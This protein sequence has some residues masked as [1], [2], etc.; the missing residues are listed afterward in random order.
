MKKF[1]VS[2]LALL[3]L[4]ACT[5]I[6]AGQKGVVKHYGRVTSVEDEGLV[7]YNPWSTDVIPV[8]VQQMKWESDT[9]AYT[10]DVQQA[11]IKF[12][13]TYRLDPSKVSLVYRT[14]GEDWPSVLI[15][16]V[17]EQSI[18]E[19]MGRSD[20]VGDAINNRG[21]VQQQIFSI[22]RQRLAK[23]NVIV[24]GFDIKDISFTKQFEE[25]VERKQI[26]VQDADTAKNKTV[27]VEENAK[28]R[29]IAAEADA[30]A[31]QIKTQALSGNAKLVE[32]EAV[33]KWDGALPQNMYG[34][35]VPFIN[36]K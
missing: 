36:V 13:L 17:V 3:A 33:Q 12:A 8:N 31:M 14:V 15:P 34:G 22:L 11:N 25:A 23:R 7:W 30:K 10:R 35:A 19:V 21:A 29:V 6:E 24:E 1:V 20:A 27:E 28:Q 9:E 5:Q 26:A 2:A 16:Q 32:Y 4:S 18:K